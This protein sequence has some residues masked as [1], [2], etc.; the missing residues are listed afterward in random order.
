M[1]QLLTQGGRK[2]EK[3][4]RKYETKISLY[5]DYNEVLKKHLMHTG[6]NVINLDSLEGGFDFVALYLHH[7][8]LQLKLSKSEEVGFKF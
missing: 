3:E 2:R 6:Y 8:H 1:Q 5:S 7:S 4:G